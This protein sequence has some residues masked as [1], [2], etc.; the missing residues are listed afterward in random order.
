MPVV[1]RAAAISAWRAISVPWSQVRVRRRC[2]GRTDGAAYEPGTCSSIHN[3]P[4]RAS[5]RTR[6]VSAGGGHGCGVTVAGPH[7]KG[8]E[9]LM[10]LGQP[11]GYA[12]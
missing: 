3:E 1:P 12:A 2:G 8:N 4:V 9:L 11:R 5:I 7:E 10:R 6:S